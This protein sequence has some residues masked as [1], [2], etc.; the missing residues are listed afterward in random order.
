[1]G[2]NKLSLLLLL[3]T[4]ALSNAQDE[5]PPCLMAK[6]YKPFNKYEYFYKTES[7]NA[8]NEAVN[9]P[10][11]SCKVEI[12]VPGTCSYILRTTECKL[13]EAIGVNADGNP[14][15]GAAAGTEDFKTAMEKHPLKFTVEGDDEIK[16]FP[17]EDELINILNIKRGIISALAVPVLEEDRNK[18]M[19]TIYG[20][21]KTDYV[22]KTREDIDTEVTLNRDLSKCDKF[23]PIKDHTSPLALITGL[24][25]PLA[26]LIWS[27]QTC[28][29]KF[30]NEQHHMT[31]GSCTEKHVLVPFSY[32]GRYG[33]TNTGKQALTLLGV[34]DYNDRVFEHNVANMKPLH[35][36]RS[37]DMSPIQDKDAALD[38]LRELSGLSKTNDG[39]KRAH[40]AHKL[41]AV[42]RKMEAETLT[43]TVPE[44][45]E[46]SRFLT[47]QALLQCGTPECNSAIMQ[48]FRTFDRSSVEIDAAVY[49]MGMIPQ[50]SRV[51]VKEMLAMAKFKPT[52]PIYY[53]LS[54]AVRRLYESDG[55]TNEI[56]A[57][58]D[59]ALEQIGDCTGDQ[60]HVF[61]SLRVIGNMVV[62]LGAARPALHSSVIQCINHPTA[63]PSVQHA[64]IQVYRQILVPE[65]GREVLMHAV[66]DRDASVQKRV[67]AYLILMKNPTPAE[68]AQLA[69]A[70]H[71]EENRQTKSFIISHIT[72][73]LSST[74]PETQ[75]LRWKVQEAFQGNEI[76]MIMEPTKLSRYYRLGSLEGNMIFESPNE[77]PREVML[78]MTLNAF[79]FDMDFIEIGMEGK[80]FEPIVEALFGDDGFFPDT[81]MKTT[82]YA[83]DNM[84]AQL[85]E[86]LDN[87]LPIMRNERKKRQ[88]IQNIVKEISDNVNKLIEDLKAQDTP[89]AM[90]YLK[91]LGAELGYLDAKDGKMIHNLLKMIP[92]DFAKRL[93][94]S[95]DNE[96]FLHYIFMDN[97]FYL[98]TGAGF[99]LR[100][101]LSG[102]FT[103]GIKG[104]LRFSPGM[105]EF[106][107]ALSSGIEFVTEIGTHFPDY[108][109]SGL[110]MH[111]N[112]YHESGLRAKL[113]VTNNQLKLSI[114]APREPTEL[115][116]VT[117]SL[118]SVVGAKILPIHANGEYINAE[119]C[120]PVFPGWKHCTVLKYPDDA[121]PYFP[122]NSDTKF[123][124]T[125]YPSVEVTE[126]T[127]TI[128]YAYEDDSDKVTFSIKAEGTPFEATNTVMLNRKQH[129]VSS[130]LLIAPLQLYSKVYAKLK[131][132]EKLTLELESDLK[133]PETTS[134]QT[135]ILKLE[136]EKIEAELKSH[137]NS[138]IQRIISNINAIET[139]VNSLIDGQTAQNEKKVRDILA[140]S[141][142]Y[143]GI[144]A[145]PVFAIPERLFL[146]VEVAAKY[147]FGHPYYTI[148]LP[149]P[150]GGKSTR[151]LNFPMTISTPNLII[152][153]LD[154]EFEAT[155]IN[156]PEV[157]I[158]VNVS[159]S[160]PTLE[161]TEMS[162]K[163]SSNFYNLETAMSAAR[164][165][166]AD[167]RYSA[168]FEVTG[169]SPVDLLSLK[170]EGSA[171]V[172]P[173]PGNSL[174]TK[175]KAVVHHKI[176]DATI[177][178][179]EEV[180][181]AE[182][183]SVKSKS[184]LDVI[185]LFGVQISLE[186]NGTF[187]V[188]DEE[189]SGDGNLEGSFEAGPV[190]GSGILTQ[191]VSLLPSRQEAKIDSSLKVDS[192]LLQARNSFALA[193][194]NGGLI[195][196]SNTAAFDDHL[197][198][199]A[200][201]TFKEFQLA[202]NTHTKTQAFGLKIQNMAET[203][204]GAEAVSVKIETSTDISEERIHSLVAGVLDINGLTIHS[205]ASAKLMGHTAAHKA[206]LNLNMDGLTTSGTTSLQSAFTMEEVKQTF[207]INYKILT[208]TAKCKTIGNIMGTR[209]NH[210]TELEMAGLSGR[211]KN[212][213]R[214]NSMVFN[215]ETNTYGTTIPFS[216]NF[217]ASA[218]GDNDI[219]LYG[220][221]NCEFNAKVLL[222][223]E[224]QSIA[225]SH[226]FNISTL[227]DIDSVNIKSHFE[228]KSDT[229]LI[230]SEQ[231]TKVTV[232]AEVNNNAI[233]QEISG[234]NTPAQFGLEGSGTVH[235]N[236]FNT[237]NTAY[238]DFVVS[239]FLKYG[240]SNDRHLISLPFLDGLLL[241]PDNIRITLVSIGETLRNYINKEGIAS[242]IHNLSQHVSDFVSNLN[243]E[244]R[245]VQLKHTLI[246]LSQEFALKLENLVASRIGAFA[247]LVSDIGNCFSEALELTVKGMLVENV[248]PK[249]ISTLIFSII[250]DVKIFLSSITT[251]SYTKLNEIFR[252]ANAENNKPD[253][254]LQI[255]SVSTALL[256]P[257]FGKLYGEVRF[258]SPVYNVR[259]SAEFKN[260]SERHPLF[261]A[262]IY[263]KG[264]SPKHNILN[265]NLDSTAQISMPKM[266]PVTVSETLKLTH[267]YLTLDQQASS[268]LNG[269]ASNNV[270]SSSFSLETLYK[271]QVKIP[272][273]SLSG[274]VTLIQNTIAFQDG[275]AITLTVKNEGSS[276]FTLEDFSEEG[277]HKSDLHL[278]MG[279]STA[280]LTFTGRTDSAH[281]QMKMKVNADA[282]ALSHIE[283]NARVETESPFIKNSLLVVSGKACFSDL[284]I[285][286]SAAHDTE[287]VGP[288][289]GVLSNTANIMTCPCVVDI[290]FQNKG[291]AKIKL[292]ESLLT[293]VDLQN[294]YTFI[295]NPDLQEFSTVAVAS[296]NHF[297]YSH[298]FTA[299]NN[300]AEMGIH[301]V[302]NSVASFEF[303]NAAEMFVPAIFKIPAVKKL[304]R[305]HDQPIDLNAKLVYQKSG[306]APLLGN[307]VSEV[308]FKSSILNLSAN[309]GIYP[310]DCL[311]HVSATT[312]SVFQEL[313]S[314]LDGSTSLTTK[315]GLKLAS[316]LS[317]ENA[318]IEGNHNSTMTLEDNFEAVLSVDTVAKIHTTSFTVNAA[319]QLSA[320]TKA[321]PKAESNLT[322]KYT[323]DQ[324]DSA[325]AGHGD[326]K[327]TLKLDATLSYI[328]FESVSQITSNSTSPDGVTIKGTLDNEANIYVKADGLKSN[329]KTT[330]NGCI[331]FRYS[332]LWFDINDLLTV[333]GGLDRIYSLLEIN[334][335]YTYIDG[336]DYDLAINHTARGKTDLVPLSTLMAAVDIFL[337]QPSYRDFDVRYKESTYSSNSFAFKTETF[338]RWYNSS[339]AIS[340]DMLND[341]PNAV[342]YE[343]SYNFT[344]PSML[345]EY[346][347]GLHI[348]PV[349]HN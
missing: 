204:A 217:D 32:K 41:V 156:L 202:L 203:R 57:V 28:N 125:L 339:T 183:L 80:G 179:E 213:V 248:V 172:E 175:V 189:I 238:Q 326:A 73:M 140:K 191:S 333:E 62:A 26:Q 300:E 218:N 281:L 285:E 294:D 18:E 227:L 258:S 66:L 245:A 63:S 182:K 24:H 221:S 117:S 228:S 262:F 19:P 271:H 93:L 237:A 205:D 321:H 297:N 88:A 79:G 306:F 242:K 331:G 334:S 341:L 40:L 249:H 90:V 69:A 108:V 97:E 210:N 148:T 145:L 12:A 29:Y 72:N 165:P 198:N 337:T 256:V 84:P 16:L 265:Y 344:S 59:Y 246:S 23:R 100:V 2:E 206:N 309:T 20:L 345:L 308:S 30:D 75:D 260:A 96:L 159:L 48:I 342:V 101:A 6:R 173:T 270:N 283:F 141:A 65:E 115:I 335:N 244:R 209:I 188:D 232:K 222:K 302:V 136:N 15:F 261:T 305:S 343:C 54:Q 327:N 164:D 171:L 291:N 74:A 234:Y 272:S 284:S 178:V 207:E 192:T 110:E 161:M 303:L 83:T 286:I 268:T 89:E 109:L 27:N 91:L 122:L 328:T 7:L 134:V 264:T 68:L 116:S 103:P 307:L 257:S 223:V 160:V 282:V 289:S 211:I 197:T 301:T 329:L 196:L 233:N 86:V 176:I 296:F 112:I 146:N 250:E 77:L 225:H 130:E 67:A 314:K 128:N 186:H 38:V 87:M 138:E 49:G 187:E 105:K 43:A 346:Q 251:Q 168:K 127:A 142:A 71:V 4:V 153:H 167:L 235:T 25:H 166:S 169:T 155:S 14:V 215:V 46:I 295:F 147:L 60:E 82:L 119:V 151:D 304:K 263:S 139:I 94:S 184:K 219:Y 70:V 133:L 332:K 11:A 107:F 144:P 324:S 104:G 255:P 212:R 243:F 44:A 37:V 299:N 224:P 5:G 154:L 157:S 216:F 254:P 78:E 21:C 269:S 106:A 55:V 95:V 347:G 287:L 39:R 322:I 348:I 143:L 266:S 61:L 35:L 113:S 150:L 236:L 201:I 22:V 252:P 17:E 33:V 58:A 162:G 126:Y 239:G 230:P 85:I 64:A 76:G 137:V 118:V 114:P 193:F 208:A 288:V 349:Y 241:V 194:A 45:L 315:S 56:Q 240:K 267:V 92:T 52:K 220:H 50:S 81:V 53:A 293:T 325:A 292:Y 13:R 170:V 111:T 132:D 123:T 280:K 131:H 253:S 190:N 163:L 311:M 124:V 200:N 51:L 277:T 1:M 158:P 135:L 259:T 318:H 276:K 36:D 31:S 310:K 152:P 317:L 185:S 278:N 320:D 279:L 226:E 98:P 214:F 229:L 273:Q 8:L 275:A 290:H 338:S 330:G 9:G 319:H 99:P 34:A 174:M 3:S 121:A 274:E 120:A 316:S 181:L 340:G 195:I 177:R 323:F 312:A 313:N 298:N 129:T 231:K 149:L 47:Y 199:T 247:K 336:T 10:E 42:I 102:T 180:K